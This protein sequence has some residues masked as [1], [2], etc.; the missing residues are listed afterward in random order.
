[1]H[2]VE[3]KC[4]HAHFLNKVYVIPCVMKCT[5][6][7]PQRGKCYVQQQKVTQAHA[8][9]LGL[10][11]LGLGLKGLCAPRVSEGGEIVDVFSTP[12]YDA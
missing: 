6:P 9:P 3:R 5:Q 4:A 11:R 7:R 8:Q 1:M 2:D 10:K 12:D